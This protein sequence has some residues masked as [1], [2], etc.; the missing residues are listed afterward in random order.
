MSF[1]NV[2]YFAALSSIQENIQT[3]NLSFYREM[4]DVEKI[5]TSY[6]YKIKEELNVVFVAFTM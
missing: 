4:N 1:S 6:T 3:S 5:N 2:V